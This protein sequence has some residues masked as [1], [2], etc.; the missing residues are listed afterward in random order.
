MSQAQDDAKKKLAADFR[1]A[2][3]GGMP[4]DS[5][6]NSGVPFTGEVLKESAKRFDALINDPEFQSLILEE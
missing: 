3:N 4:R 1:A 2:L 6:D 5:L